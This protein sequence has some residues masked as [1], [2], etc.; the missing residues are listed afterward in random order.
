MLWP[1]RPEA[2]PANGGKAE[3]GSNKP[4]A[5]RGME[6][7][8]VPEPSGRP[9]RRRALSAEGTTS[10]APVGAATAHGHIPDTRSR[11]VANNSCKSNLH[12]VMAG[13]I[14]GGRAERVPFRGGPKLRSLPR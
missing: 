10:G 3:T 9:P 7:P 2:H 14:A 4:A 5:C 11:H 12:W 13:A 1:P 8:G 6:R